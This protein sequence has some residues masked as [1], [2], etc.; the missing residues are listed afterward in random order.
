MYPSAAVGVASEF[1][2]PEILREA[3]PKVVNTFMCQA[4]VLNFMSLQ[5]LHVADIAGRVHTD[6][7][8]LGMLTPGALHKFYRR[9][10]HPSFRQNSAL[11]R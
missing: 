8:K 11:T 3:G 2:I 5:G 1:N 9:H 10:L 6:T 7:G 4:F